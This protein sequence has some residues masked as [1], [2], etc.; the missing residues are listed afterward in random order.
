MPRTPSI[1]ATVTTRADDYG[2]WFASVALDTPMTVHEANRPAVRSSM[3]SRART[4]I[5]RERAQRA[6]AGAEITVRVILV[7]RVADERGRVTAF[8]Y[9]EP[10][11]AHGDRVEFAE[12]TAQWA[13]GDRYGTVVK[14]GREYVHVRTDTGALVRIAEEHMNA[15]QS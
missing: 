5:R 1:P 8:E 14:Y 13:A 10:R 11:F 15:A 9:A 12:H 7:R 2:R 6:P 3:S 4:A